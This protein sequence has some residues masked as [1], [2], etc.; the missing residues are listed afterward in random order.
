MPGSNDSEF[1]IGVEMAVTH[2]REITCDFF[3]VT[4]GQDGKFPFFK[5]MAQ[6]HQRHPT[7]QERNNPT[8]D[9][10]H[11]VYGWMA[12]GHLGEGAL[13]RLRTIHNA[14][15]AG[16]ASDEL[17]DL[18]LGEGEALTEYFCFSYF[19]E[20]RTMVVH[21]NREAGNYARLQDYLVA[22]SGVGS[23]HLSP[24]ITGGALERLSRMQEFTIA[25]LKLAI[26][27]NIGKT[28]NR[29]VDDMISIAHQTGAATIDVRIS[30]DR[31]KKT[32]QDSVRE[33]WATA[34]SFV[35]INTRMAEIRGRDRE[36]PDELLTL[37]LLTDTMREKVEL[38]FKGSRPAL[39]DIHTALRSAYER[40][41]S[42]I[43]LQFLPTENSTNEEAS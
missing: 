21:R 32:L 27:D 30:M 42:E 4:C 26:P 25:E 36:N 43:A 17:R 14:S 41:R 7:A 3:R 1:C 31:S 19:D 40:R 23:V 15:I 28:G 29:S 5:L 8:K 37:D 6:L 9:G 10:Y 22:K 16:I 2:R 11:R 34:V 18:V 24:I 39:G 13:L 20:Y 33:A 12:L 38:Q 35:G